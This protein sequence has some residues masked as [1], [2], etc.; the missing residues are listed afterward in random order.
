MATEMLRPY[1]LETPSKWWLTDLNATAH[2]FCDYNWSIIF[3]FAVLGL[4]LSLVLN[5]EVFTDTQTTELYFL[6]YSCS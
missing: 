6:F 3:I 5:W 2:V 4:W 1:S